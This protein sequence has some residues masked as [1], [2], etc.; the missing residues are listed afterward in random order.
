MQKLTT[1]KKYFLSR[2][3]VI[4][5]TTAQI[6]AIFIVCATAQSA[7][8]PVRRTPGA[9]A[10]QAA[11]DLAP[12]NAVSVVVI[13]SPKLAADD[14]A[15]C[16]ARLDQA[17][18]VLPMRP[19]DLAKAQ[20]GFGAGIDD[21]ASFVMW[22]QPD[23]NGLQSAMLIPVTNAKV[24][25]ESNFKAI[26]G[27]STDQAVAYEHPKLGKIF[28][29]AI[30]RHI[31][32]SPSAAIVK[33]YVAAPGLAASLQK[34]LGERGLALFSSGDMGAW[35]G[36]QALKSLREQAAAATSAATPAATPAATSAATPAP[37]STSRA[38]QL[39]QGVTDGV[40]SIDLDPM[41]VSFRTFAV[42]DAASELGRSTQGGARGNAA[43][44]T[45]LPKGP[46]IFAGAADMQGLGGADACIDLMK[47]VPG[48]P[49]LPEWVRENR[50]LMQGAQFAIYP[51]K[52]GLAG[53]GLLNEAYL[54]CSTTDAAKAKQLLREWMQSLSGIEGTTERKVLWESDKAIKDGAIADAY[55]ITEAT[56]VEQQPAQGEPAAPKS[57]TR[58][59]ADPMQRLARMMVFGPRGPM[60][61]AKTFPDGMLVTF[62][63]RPDVLQRGITLTEGAESLQADP[64]IVALRAWLSPDPDMVAYVGV[65][66]L[67]NVVRQ[68]ARSFPGAGIELPDAPP[69]MEPIAISIEVQDGHVETATMMPTAVI[70]VLAELYRMQTRQQDERLDALDADEAADA[71][72]KAPVKKSTAPLGGA[73]QKPSTNNTRAT[74][75]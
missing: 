34:R 70:G 68:A 43:Q 4:S 74:S 41:G 36:D 32:V 42:M 44:L 37:T 50:N 58:R 6:L 5:C 7:Q 28:A 9:Q 47:L 17:V 61:F 25:L 45:R 33:A 30:D 26:P 12:S 29:R 40:I 65:G 19:L 75:P 22:F 55:A 53:G 71:K 59:N 10:F 27:D 3:F 63:Q 60:G 52:L 38:D 21:A 20:F 49:E 69:G 23:G 13:P 66:S 51:S 73:A 15:E 2:T 46:F 11:L 56:A 14:L 18:G 39:A 62:S 54:W 67:L 64:V 1:P 31:L 72:P 8:E 16:M 24:F 35:A 48:A 57:K